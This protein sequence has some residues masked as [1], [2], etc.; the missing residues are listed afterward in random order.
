[1]TDT[2]GHQQYA[3]DD[4]LSDADLERYARHVILDELGDEGQIRLINSRVAVVGA[5]GLGSPALLYLAA[6]GIGTIGIIDDDQVD[7]TNLQ[8]QIVH[9]DASVGSPKA[10]SARERLTKLNPAI[11]LVVHRTRLTDGNARTIL[12]EYD[13]VLDGTDNYATRI[14]IND[15]C[16]GLKIPLISASVVR[17]EGQLS[18]FTAYETGPCYRCVFPQEPEPGLVPRC[19]SAGILGPVAGVMGTL[20][21]TEALKQ[22]LGLGT[23]MVGQLMLYDALDQSMQKIKT[24]K[25][26]ACPTCGTPA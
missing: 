21:A 18:T 2:S 26:P 7:R 1:M 10:E 22:I 23:G 15:V 19:D 12:S 3:L 14:M 20:Q 8:R 17:F 9:S 24:R 16:Y 11:N 5:G 25:D 4:D 6:A 13:L